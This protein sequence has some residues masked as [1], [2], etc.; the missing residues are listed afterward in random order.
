MSENHLGIF[1]SVRDRHTAGSVIKSAAEVG[2]NL[3]AAAKP[4]QTVRD[5]LTD[6]ISGMKVVRREPLKIV[7]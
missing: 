2:G 4:G 3:S 6:T 7:R 5:V 1:T